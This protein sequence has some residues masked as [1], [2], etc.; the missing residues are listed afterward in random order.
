MIA[1]VYEFNY[2]ILGIDRPFVAP[3]AHDERRWLEGAI[4]EELHELTRATDITDQV[5]ALI[6]LAYFAIGGLARLGL[7]PEQAEKCFMVIHAANMTKTKGRKTRQTE[8]D[9][10]ATKPADWSAPEEALK[11]II[12]EWK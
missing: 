9:L 5:D 8:H 2:R 4:A 3:L 11:H 7:S 1:K 12:G 6:D 10:D